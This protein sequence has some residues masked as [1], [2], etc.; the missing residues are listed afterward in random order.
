MNKYQKELSAFRPHDEIQSFGPVGMGYN[1]IGTAGHGYLVVPVTDPFH[2]I[3]MSI[4]E[5][6]YIGQN[7]VYLEEDCEYPKF[8]K[9]VNA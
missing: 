3:A 5:F 4:C 7:A 2:P 6:G 8:R 1:F 9:M